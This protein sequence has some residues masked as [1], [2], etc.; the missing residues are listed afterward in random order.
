MQ[1]NNIYTIA[2]PPDGA[3]ISNLNYPNDVSVDT[4]G[5]VYIADTYNNKI[6]FIPVKSDTYFGQVMTANTIYT[7]AGTIEGDFNGA[8][9]TS[10]LFRPQSV[11]VDVFGNLYV[12]VGS[13]SIIEYSPD[14]IKF[15]PVISGTYFGQV[16]EANNI[17]TIAGTTQG[18]E[19]GQL[20]TS[21]LNIPY[22]ISVD[23]RGNVYIADSNNHKIK[24]ILTK[25]Y[26]DNVFTQT[27]PGYKVNN[28]D[29]LCYNQ[30]I[31]SLTP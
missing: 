13:E 20:S 26:Y 14:K 23:T 12:S 9:S 28:F 10:E 5:N 30:G 7:I 21:K 3:S 11:K 22:G 24:K 8:L 15:I 18:D 27:T 6:K 17:Y 31:T 25:Y 19:V 29:A 2:G 4:L 16:M 1:V